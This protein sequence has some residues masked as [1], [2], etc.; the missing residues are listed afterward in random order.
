MAHRKRMFA[1]LRGA[2]MHAAL[3]ASRMHMSMIRSAPAERFDGGL[4][5][6]K[7]QIASHVIAT[8]ETLLRVAQAFKP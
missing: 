3:A 8:Q 6:K 2:S 4:V 7:V 5:G 1:V